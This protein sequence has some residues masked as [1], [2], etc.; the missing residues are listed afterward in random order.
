MPVVFGGSGLGPTLRGQPSNVYQLQPCEAKLVPA[1]SWLGKLG[2][3]TNYQVLDTVTGIWRNVGDGG[4]TVRIESDG[5]NHRLCNQTG[6]TVGAVITNAG[7]GYTSAPTVTPSSG[8]SVWQ[9]IVGGAVNTSVTVTNGGTNYVYPP[10]VAFSAPPTPGI[11]ATGYATISGG[12]VTG[13]TVT[14]QGA[15]YTFAPTISFINDARDSTGSNAQ[16]TCVL[17]GSGT[18]T[19]LLATDHGTPL[20]SVPTLA[21]SGGGGSAAAA[22]AIMCWSI[23]GITFSGGTGY[24]VGAGAFEMSYVPM[25][26][27]ATPIYTNPD[28]QL[29]LVRMRQAVIYVPTTATGAPTSTG[30]VVIDGGIYQNVPTALIIQNSGL[31]PS[32]T[33]ATLAMG[34][35]QDFTQ[36]YP[37]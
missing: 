15:G 11:Q 21:F 34:G 23:T 10:E 7:T 12:V 16:G 25:L 32:A 29:R 13:V 9:A 19:G 8:S 20:T 2:L 17:T 24:T 36:L 26:T 6:G 28:T 18:I 37:V 27:A 1:G 31:Y 30:E 35:N 4:I 22:T 3:Y 14:N 33:T 5:V